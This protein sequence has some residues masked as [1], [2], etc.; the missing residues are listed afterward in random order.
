MC[1]QWPQIAELALRFMS[2]STSKSDSERI[3]S[4]QKN[5][6]AL[7]RDRFKIT[8]TEY[9]V[10]RSATENTAQLGRVE[11]GRTNHMIL[12]VRMIPMTTLMG[13][14]PILGFELPHL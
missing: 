8:G 13:T 10:G 1:A 6:P 3:L 4:M 7:H 12:R 14:I 5:I 9:R 11:P 2:C